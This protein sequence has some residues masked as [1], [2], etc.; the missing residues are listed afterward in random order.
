M[1]DLSMQGATLTITGGGGVGSVTFKD[2]S[3]DGTPFG[4]GDLAPINTSRTLNGKLLAWHNAKTMPE[5]TLSPIPNSESD[6][7][8]RAL[9]LSCLVSPQGE[10]TELSDVLLEKAVWNVPGHK[11]SD[12]STSSSR[13]FVYTNGFLVGG[14]S[15]LGT[16]G[17]GRMTG[18]PYRF[19]WE[20]M[21]GPE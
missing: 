8:L 19:Q 3:D 4:H 20:D 16:T 2:L 15:S 17:E 13:T 10:A 1:T 14:T 18:G 11:N 9:L 6:K 21:K 12:G 5:F 7:A